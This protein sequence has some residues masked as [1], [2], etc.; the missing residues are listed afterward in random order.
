MT[1]GVG[2]GALDSRLRGNDVVGCGNDG[3]TMG[4]A[5]PNSHST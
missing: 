3:G 5:S 1:R 4:R 2:S